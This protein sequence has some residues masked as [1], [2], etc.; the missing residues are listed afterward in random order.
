M[1]IRKIAQLGEPVLRRPAREL[2]ADELSSSY[3]TRLIEDLIDTMRDADGAGL[4]APQIYESV[5]LVVIEVRT[6]PR[7]PNVA[8]IPLTLLVNPRVTP[9]GL[10]TSGE[11]PDEESISVYEGCLSVAGL[12]GRVRRP[13]R[14]RVEALDP[15]GA[16][17][18]FL[19]EGFRAAVVQH[20]TDHLHG[21]LFVD[22]APPQSLTFLREYER[23]VP[24]EQRVVDAARVTR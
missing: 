22:R 8:P 11:L 3:V 19:W 6:N 13:R 20:E 17:V 7:Y 1:A 2:S 4:A 23:Y 15:S 16:A 9:L 18:T 14:V 10:T 24:P 21:T 5:Q 12:R